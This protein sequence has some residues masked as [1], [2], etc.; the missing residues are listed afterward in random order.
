MTGRFPRHRWSQR[1]LV[2]AFHP[3]GA[4]VYIVI[5]ALVIYSLAVYG[6]ERQTVS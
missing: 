2:D 4:F 3:V 5:A 6:G 1:H